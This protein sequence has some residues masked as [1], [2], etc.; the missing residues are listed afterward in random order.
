MNLSEENPATT[1]R[2][3][4]CFPDQT[5][6]LVAHDCM[7]GVKREVFVKMLS[8]NLWKAS[9]RFPFEHK[10]A[11]AVAG[12]DDSDSGRIKEDTWPCIYESFLLNFYSK[13]NMIFRE[14]SLCSEEGEE[15]T[16][17]YF[18]CDI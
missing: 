8:R 2:Q 12:S 6:F 9:R 16:E 7:K 3:C 10:L 4:S 13:P 18:S 11:M 14:V 1:R 15:E 17:N 5:E